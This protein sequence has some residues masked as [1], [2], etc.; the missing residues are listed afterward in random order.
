MLSLNLLLYH[1]WPGPYPYHNPSQ[2]L[3]QTTHFFAMLIQNYEVEQWIGL[4]KEFLT[5][6]LVYMLK[7]NATIMPKNL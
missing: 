4:G 3:E 7:T 5:A 2:V 1:T 6:W